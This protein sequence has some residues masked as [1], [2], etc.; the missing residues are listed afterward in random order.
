VFTGATSGATASVD[1]GLSGFSPQLMPS[2]WYLSPGSHLTFSGTGFAPG[3]DLAMTFNAS[4]THFTVAGNG[5]VSTIPVNIPFSGSVA[6]FSFTSSVTHVTNSFDIT[7][8]ALSPGIWLSTYYDLPGKPLTVFG[9]GFAGNETVHVTFEATVLGDVTTDGGG[10]FTL[11]STVPFGPSGSKTI[12]AH[13]QSS[14]ANATANFTQPQIF[15]NVQLGAYAGAPGDAVDFIG[16]GFLPNEPIN[17]TTDRTGG[18]VVASF[19]SDNSGS[20]N[21]SSYHLP[22]GFTG[23]PLTLTITGAHSFTGKSIIYYVTGP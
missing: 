15:V 7:I 18:T 5:T 23:G 1:V 4:T 10:N 16:S 8:A 21:N 6:H 19:T 3:E 11:N 12:T 14:G 2:S 13:G 20:F 22:L 9:G 17:I